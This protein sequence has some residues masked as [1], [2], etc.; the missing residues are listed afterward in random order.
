MDFYVNKKKMLK[1]N[2]FSLFFDMPRIPQNLRERAIGILNAGMTMNDVAM[3]IG[4]STCA[5]RHLR[6]RFQATGRT[7]GRP[8]CERPSVTTRGQDRYV[9]TLTCAIASKLLQL[10]LLTPMVHMITVYLPKLCAIACAR[11][12]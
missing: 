6:Q 2:Q 1:K 11:E 9:Q 3:S 5:I 7:K 8:R 4:C 12:G 10:L